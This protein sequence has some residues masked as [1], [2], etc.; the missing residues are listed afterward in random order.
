MSASA[1]P[2]T[3]YVTIR[4]NT[5]VTEKWTEEWLDPQFNSNFAG[6]D[7]YL[8]ADL[9]DVNNVNLGEISIGT[10]R[11]ICAS[12][13]RLPTPLGATQVDSPWPSGIALEN[14]SYVVLSG[15]DHAHDHC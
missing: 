1:N 11:R 2:Q 3:G 7:L 12:Q 5:T 8:T 14:V 4:A 9:Y 10:Y 13:I 6:P 15:S